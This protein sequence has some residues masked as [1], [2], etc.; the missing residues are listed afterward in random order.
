MIYKVLVGAGRQGSLKTILV[1]EKTF[2]AE[3][4]DPSDYFTSDVMDIKDC[5]TVEITG[6]AEHMVPD[7][8]KD[9]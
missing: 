9:A 2:N 1:E 6:P 5:G 4:G 7:T 3:G 8:M